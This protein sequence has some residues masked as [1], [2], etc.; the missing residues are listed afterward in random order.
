[1]P[2]WGRQ[3]ETFAKKRRHSVSLRRPHPRLWQRV[4]GGLAV[5]EAGEA[6][7]RLPFCCLG[8]PE[9]G[10]GLGLVQPERVVPAAGV[11]VLLGKQDV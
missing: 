4:N 2:F 1:M 10:L 8:Q 5:A 11:F 9:N 6:V 3:P 7:F